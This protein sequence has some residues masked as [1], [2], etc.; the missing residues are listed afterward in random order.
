[1]LEEFGAQEARVPREQDGSYSS[2]RMT[3]EVW[4]QIHWA[5]I[6]TS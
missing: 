1:M 6:I 4:G 5:K 3:L 2:S